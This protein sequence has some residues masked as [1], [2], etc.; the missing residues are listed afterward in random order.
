MGKPSSLEKVPMLRK[1]EE[2]KTREQPA[3]RCMD[4]VTVLM[5]VLLGDLKEQVGGRS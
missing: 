2:D 3:A 4:S 1:M 5:S